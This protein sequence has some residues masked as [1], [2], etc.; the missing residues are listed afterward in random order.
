MLFTYL[1][2]SYNFIKK[3]TKEG[4]VFFCMKFMI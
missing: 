4:G 1:V 3:F 2:L